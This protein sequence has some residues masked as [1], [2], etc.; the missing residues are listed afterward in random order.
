MVKWLRSRPPI[1]IDGGPSSNLGWRTFFFVSIFTSHIFIHFFFGL[2]LYLSVT[3]VIAFLTYP[4]YSVTGNM[5]TMPHRFSQYG[6][7]PT[8]KPNFTATASYPD[9]WRTIDIPLK[10]VHRKQ[11]YCTWSEDNHHPASHRNCSSPEPCT[12]IALWHS[13]DPLS[14]ISR[15]AQL[16]WTDVVIASS[17]ARS[18]SVDIRHLMLG[19]KP[20]GIMLSCTNVSDAIGNGLWKVSIV[21]MI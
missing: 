16:N 3:W 4:W 10:P 21:V 7:R 19:F 1:W 18:G 6:H 15:E 12:F 2:I 11:N 14:D 13:D 20:Q 9:Q 5:T 17:V 8:C